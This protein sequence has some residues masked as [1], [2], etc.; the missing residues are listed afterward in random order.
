MLPLARS[1]RLKNTI[2][3]NELETLVHELE[4]DRVEKIRKLKITMERLRRARMQLQNQKEIL[5]RLRARIV[6]LTP[7]AKN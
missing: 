3:S 6:E 2:T 5:K 7:T 1:K 4:E